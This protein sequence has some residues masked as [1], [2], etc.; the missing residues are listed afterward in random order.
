M[1]ETVRI[2]GL[3]RDLYDGDDTFLDVSLVA[4]LRD[5]QAEKAAGKP[6]GG[7]SIWEI[8]N[9]LVAWRENVLQRVSGTAIATPLHNYFVPI[10]DTSEN[11]W[12]QTLEK[13]EQSQKR[14]ENF[15]S[16][17]R[18]EDLTG[19]YSGNGLTHY[20]HIHSIIQHD[21][22]HLGQIVMLAKHFV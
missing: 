14:W 20:Q 4:T 7:N 15:L 9:H 8:T 13:L 18:D 5:I 17:M 22:Y 19:I 1:K 10:A 11:A 16:K 6:S 2:L 12:Q 3:F 21:A